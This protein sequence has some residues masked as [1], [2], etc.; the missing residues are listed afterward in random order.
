MLT[1]ISLA[2]PPR[3]PLDPPTAWGCV[4]SNQLVLPG[5][6]S[7]VAGRRIGYSQA[8]LALVGVVLSG[9]FFTWFMQTWFRLKQ[10]PQDWQELKGLLQTWKPYLKIG[11]WGLLCFLSSWCW[12]LATSIGIVLESRHHQAPGEANGKKTES[13]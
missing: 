3:R 12:A 6:G 11:G 7:L 5:L 13:K 2:L 8:A 9:I 10:W 1:K 4:M